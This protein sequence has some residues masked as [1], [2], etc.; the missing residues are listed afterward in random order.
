MQW[1][2]STGGW[3]TKKGNDGWA[4]AYRKGHDDVDGH[5]GCRVDARPERPKHQ[6]VRPRHG[7]GG[8]VEEVWRR[9][10]EGLGGRRA[11]SEG[12]SMDGSACWRRLQGVLYLSAVH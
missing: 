9:C 6:V 11:G 12:L 7:C 3:N 1:R 5:Q 4:W 2:C 10:G 8:G